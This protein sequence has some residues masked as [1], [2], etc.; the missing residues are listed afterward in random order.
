MQRGVIDNPAAALMS[1]LG[2]KRTLA[3]EPSATSSVAERAVR[4]RPIAD[5]RGNLCYA[6]LAWAFAKRPEDVSQHP[7]SRG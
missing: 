7:M 6:D 3:R 1:A 2:G 4:C 5:V